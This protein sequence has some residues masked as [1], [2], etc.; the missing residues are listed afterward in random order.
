MFN[1][2]ENM[3]FSLNKSS[4]TKCYES[5]GN[6][7]GKICKKDLREHK[8]SIHSQ[9]KKSYGL[10]LSMVYGLWLVV[11]GISQFLARGGSC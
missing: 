9:C 1:V 7:F 8:L 4:L 10:E 5:P 3:L 11:Y 6:I 2:T